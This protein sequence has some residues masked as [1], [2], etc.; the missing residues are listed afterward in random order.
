MSLKRF[1]YLPLHISDSTICVVTVTAELILR[2]TD[3]V[4]V[5][6]KISQVKLFEI[7]TS[8]MILQTF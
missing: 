4:F 7:S 5:S 1:Q 8:N 2:S 6:L 3:L